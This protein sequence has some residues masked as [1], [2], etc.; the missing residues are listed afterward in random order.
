MSEIVRGYVLTT[1][2]NNGDHYL[3]RYGMWTPYADITAGYVHTAQELRS[4]RKPI[5]EWEIQPDRVS[6]A[7]YNPDTNVVL[8]ME[9]LDFATALI[10]FNWVS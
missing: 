6:V 7:E 8:V 10:L 3:G 2:T 1:K 5:S 9:T 4:L